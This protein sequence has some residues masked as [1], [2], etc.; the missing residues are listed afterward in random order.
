MINTII[1]N[2]DQVEA[3]CA[4]NEV[5]AGESTKVGYNSTIPSFLLTTINSPV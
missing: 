2:R 4:V 1:I 3:Q 5:R